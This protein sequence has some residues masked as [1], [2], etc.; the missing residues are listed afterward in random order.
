MTQEE[1]VEAAAKA[2]KVFPLPNVVLF[3][4]VAIPLHIFEPRYRALVK[5][6][7]AGDGVLALA[8]PDLDETPGGP[9]LGLQ[10]IACAGA[11]VWH[12]P[13][14]DGRYNIMLQGVTR[15]RLLDEHPRRRLYR[16]LSSQVVVDPPYDGPEAMLL[17]QAVWEL[18]TRLPE[19]VSEGLFQLAGRGEAGALADRVAAMV[20]EDVEKRQEILGELNVVARLSRVLS[21]LSEVIAR[22]AGRP[23][24]PMS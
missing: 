18:S 6:A 2:L 3:P 23:G 7:L 1:R 14:P 22:L 5:D 9:D 13:L 11:I 15:V 10:P 19:E 16:E 12:E 24:G 17:R 21:E 8:R 20:V 4:G